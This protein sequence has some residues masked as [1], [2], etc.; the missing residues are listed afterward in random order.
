MLRPALPKVPEGTGVNAAGLNHCATVS[1]PLRITGEVRQ[2][3]L[4]GTHVV[5]SLGYRER[6][7]RSRAEDAADQPPA[8]DVTG[9]AIL[10]R[11]AC[12]RPNGNSDD[13]VAHESMA[14][15]EVARP[16]PRFEIPS[17]LRASR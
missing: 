7:P 11:T 4:V 9:D 12:P 8:E 5:V 15:V 16:L 3:C 14:D 1:G 17:V 2:A 10:Q 13:E 6:P